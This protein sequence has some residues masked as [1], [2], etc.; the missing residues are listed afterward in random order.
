MAQV[1]II[2]PVYNVEKYI[3][4]A[5]DSLIKQTY[6]DIEIIIVDDGSND[7]S[8]DII[9]AYN[10]SRIRI[11]HQSN[12]GVASARNLG[13]AKVNSEYVMFLDGDDYYEETCVEKALAAINKDKVDLVIFGARYLDDNN[14]FIKNV[15][16]FKKDKGRLSY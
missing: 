10:D 5:I 16:P 4:M 6:Q 7:N 2:V 8:L 15:I 12:N 14:L 13:L 1:S 11:Y 3:K 9:K